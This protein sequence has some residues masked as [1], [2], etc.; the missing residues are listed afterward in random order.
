ME[1]AA[2]EEDDDRE[3]SSSMPRVAKRNIRPS[4]SQSLKLMKNPCWIYDSV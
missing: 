3:K 1:A 2:D 4:K